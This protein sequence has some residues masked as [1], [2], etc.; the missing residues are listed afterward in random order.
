MKILMLGWEYPPHISGGLGT[1]CEGL[2][3]GL[4]RLKVAVH[5][6][7][8]QISGNEYAPH[9]TLVASYS[10]DS[11]SQ[12]GASLSSGHS[13]FMTL[14]KHSIPAFLNPYW[15]EADYTAR[16]SS[17]KQLKGDLQTLRQSQDGKISDEHEFFQSADILKKVFDLKKEPEKNI[18]RY[19]HDI[20]GE[21]SRYTD[22]IVSQMIDADFDVIHAHDWMTFPAGVA[23]SRLTGKPLIVHVHSLEFD[24]SGKNGN[25]KISEF[26]SLGLHAA[27][28]VIAVSYYTKSIIQKEHGVSES[29]ISVVHNGVYTKSQLSPYRESR[30]KNRK[31]VLFLGRI[32][33][34]KGPD[35]FVEAA[36]HVIPHIPDVLFVMA[37]SGDMLQRL[38]HRVKELGIENHFV[39]TGFLRGEEV[40]EMF[41]L[42]DLYV[43]P[44]VSEPFG[45]SA[46]EAISFETPAII[47][48][49]SG[50][51]EVLSHAL[52]FDFWDIKKLSD[53]IINGLIHPELRRDMISMA[54][55]ELKRLHW[56][57]AA[58]KVVDIYTKCI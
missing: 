50:V 49:Q 31:V 17:L 39:F 56:D 40:E 19:S 18:E 20:F 21:V 8:P 57:A 33:F 54:R 25:H 4:S 28:H 53:L 38:V 22:N 44:S 9:M 5:F 58:Q 43:M 48:K 36:A 3:I 23:L 55:E 7:V 30:F 41:S 6:V 13:S 45:I 32:T 47:S 26:E 51:S 29:K 11:A 15:N 10:E 12:R 34:Q 37:G 42:A 14:Y 35:Y 52:K 2:T 24:R 16:I 46:L 27:H 1:A